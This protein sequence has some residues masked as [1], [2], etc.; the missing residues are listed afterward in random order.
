[1]AGG[2]VQLAT[3]HGQIYIAAAGIAWHNLELGA[4]Q[5]VRYLRI[6]HGGRTRPRRANRQCLLLGV[7]DGRDAGRSRYEHDVVNH[8]EIANPVEFACVELNAGLAERL[9]G[10]RRLA[11]TRDHGAV[12]WGDRVEPVRRAPTAGARHV[13][14]HDRGIAGDV[15]ADESREQAA[16]SVITFAP[17]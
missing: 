2:S 16:L 7:I 6:E 13:L 14:R 1:M 15:L 9:V 5:I 11:E 8:H 17:A 3:V 10:R 4:E 12:L